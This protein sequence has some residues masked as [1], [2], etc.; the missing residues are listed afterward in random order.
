MTHNGK[1]QLIVMQVNDNKIHDFRK[2]KLGWGWNGINF[3][4]I[5]ETPGKQKK[6][7]FL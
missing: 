6:A 2:D 3:K 5:D 4:I 7:T 1:A